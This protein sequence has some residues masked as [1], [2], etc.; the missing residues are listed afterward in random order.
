MKILNNKIVRILQITLLLVICSNI[1][2]AQP[3]AKSN[4][5]MLKPYRFI[6]SIN[7][8]HNQ[9]TEDAK[10]S[11]TILMNKL[12]K[13]KDIKEDFEIIICNSEKEILEEIKSDFDFLLVTAVEM[14]AVK[15]S[16]RAKPVLINQSQN[17]YGFIYYLITN[18]DNR[19]NNI[20]DLKDGS[21]NLLT[22]APGQ[23]PSIWLD[24]ILRDHKLPAKELFFEDINYDNNA[25]NVV[26]SVF[27]N[28]A[29]ASIVSKASFELLCELNPQI[30]NKIKIIKVSKP[31]LFG[32]VH[33]M[34]KNLDKEREKLVYD[35]LL[36]L[37]KDAY[38]KQLLNMFN[39]DKIVPYK[40]EYAQNFLQ[41]YK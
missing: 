27:F 29:S 11:T 40:E 24:K 19:I 5:D 20:E 8:F 7:L 38:G 21:I 41:L 1:V 25:T 28:K 26:L 15:K 10:A 2:F 33:F 9:K 6:F 3:D 17:S 14:A 31:L 34:N 4:N 23:V 30:P 16:G 18:T 39:V 35:T 37:D 22:R 36:E 13:D 32:V 12:K